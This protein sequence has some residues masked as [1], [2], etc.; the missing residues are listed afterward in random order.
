MKKKSKTELREAT[1]TKQNNEQQ[2][3]EVILKS[4][5]GTRTKECKTNSNEFC[6]MEWNCCCNSI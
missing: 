2:E 5:K 4:I 3:V 6:N 1:K